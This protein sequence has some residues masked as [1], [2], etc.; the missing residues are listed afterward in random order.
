[1]FFIAKGVQLGG[2]RLVHR[3]AKDHP[4]ATS[5]DQPRY[6]TL[7]F[8]DRINA[9]LYLVAGFAGPVAGLGQRHGRKTA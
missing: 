1:V 6:R 8:L 4:L 3:F 5:L 2:K 7:P 9:A